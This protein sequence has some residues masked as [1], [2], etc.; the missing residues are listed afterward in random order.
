MLGV[1]AEDQGNYGR[2][3]E[4][5]TEAA[6]MAAR[7]GDRRGTALALL[8]LGMVAFGQADSP[9]A[10]V[11]CEQGMAHAHELGSNSRTYLGTYYLALVAVE[12]GDPP[13][14]AVR[15]HEIV[16]WLEN[17]GAF[18]ATWQ[19][20][21]IDAAGRNLSG[22]ATLAAVPGLFEVA[23]RLFGTAAAGYE[24]LGA[25]P[26]LPEHTGFDQ[27]L[28]VVREQL[29]SD[30]FAAAWATGLA[31]PPFEV[32]TCINEVLAVAQNLP[33][34]GPLSDANNAGR[35]DRELE[36]LRLLVEGL[37]DR[38]IA[39]RLYISPPTAMRHVTNILGKFDAHSRTAAVSIVLRRGLI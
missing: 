10:T 29:S 6:A 7:A 1:V 25:Q 17:F 39:E 16:G 11:Y 15:Q 18:G 14:A 9:G 36:V 30:L 19:R 34:P 20:R 35:T 33:V 12:S 24:W 5:L 4:L 37:P 26:A 13:L 21:S 8:H 31:M 28:T 3:F 32:L 22:N 2:A 23:A 27:A 38:G